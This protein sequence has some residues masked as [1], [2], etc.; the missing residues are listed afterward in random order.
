MKLELSLK[1]LIPQIRKRFRT[2]LI[3]AIIAGVLVLIAHYVILPERSNVVGVI[4]FSFAGIESGHSPIGNRFDPDEMKH[5]DVIRAAAELTGTS[6][7][8]ES[9]EQIGKSIYI[10]SGAPVS[11]LS[12]VVDYETTIGSEK[13]EMTTEIRK[14]SYFPT[15]FTLRFDYA[16]AGFGR[17]QGAAFLQAMMDC[18]QTRFMSEYG[19]NASIERSMRA[20]DYQDYDYDNAVA[21]LDSD[22]RLL[23]NY[24]SSLNAMDSTRFVSTQTGYSF[25]DLADAVQ[26]IRGE[27]LARIRS[28]LNTYCITRSR[29]EK[30]NFYNFKI[31]GVKRDIAVREKQL[32][33]INGLIENYEKTTAVIAG[34]TSTRAVEAGEVPVIYEVTQHSATYDGLVSKRIS[35]E[36]GISSLNEQLDRYQE[37]VRRYRGTAG[38]SAEQVEAMLQEAEEKTNRLLDAASLTAKEYYETVRLRQPMQVL[39]APGDGGFPLGALIHSSLMDGIAVE[40]LVFGL[41]IVWSLVGV[42]RPEKATSK[43]AA[44]KKDNKKKEGGQDGRD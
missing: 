1:Q 23:G 39:T 17:S 2:W 26:T 44:D 35:C 33:T 3:V 6:L 28:Y 27:N 20:F 12:D 19:Y 43:K 4:N 7:S 32:E 8:E 41:W 13:V 38:G 10:S 34:N 24:L 22:L 36:A 11:A 42:Y 9:I 40:A 37:L 25:A 21:V 29:E 31:E 15:K 5:P 18:Y 16:A 30:L 14:T